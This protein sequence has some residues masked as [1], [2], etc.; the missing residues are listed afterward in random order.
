MCLEELIKPKTRLIA[1]RSFHAYITK[2][3]PYK[4]I[5][6]QTNS[7]KNFIYKSVKIKDDEQD[8]LD[9]PLSFF[10]INNED[11]CQLIGIE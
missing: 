3:S 8:I 6:T 1:I 9:Y 10:K 2:G 5:S 4:V 7:T 11:M